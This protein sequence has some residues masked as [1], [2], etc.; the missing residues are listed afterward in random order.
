MRNLSIGVLFAAV[1]CCCSNNVV[2][3]WST[4][5]R[6]YDNNNDISKSNNKISISNSNKNNEMLSR[7]QVLQTSIEK[8]ILASSTSAAIIGG[9]SSSSVLTPTSQKTAHAACLQGDLRTECI[10]VYKVP[11]D[12]NIKAYISTPEALKEFAPDLKFVEGLEPPKSLEEA[13]TILKQSKRL[14]DTEIKSYISRGML[15]QAGKEVLTALPNINMSGRYVVQELES[16][17][18]NNDSVKTIT[19][20]DATKKD[21][22]DATTISTEETVEQ[23]KFTMIEN[24]YDL[25][26]G[27]W[28]EMD[29]EM[30]QG[31]RGELGV[32]AVAQLTILSTLK[33]ATIALDEFLVMAIKDLK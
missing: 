20:T 18:Y 6:S 22:D 8:T 17:T 9:I 29:V 5:N 15:E 10:G 30:G 21:D 27:Y 3:S 7:R 25:M 1:Y 32:S 26:N 4:N 13:L 2:R 16:R 23:L 28:G 12:E 33:D 11:L 24:Q 19:T 31:L 14:A